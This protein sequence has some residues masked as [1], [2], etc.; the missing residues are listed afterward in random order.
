VESGAV[1]RHQCIK[2]SHSAIDGVKRQARR[3]HLNRRVGI[4]CENV[5]FEDLVN[6]LL[7]VEKAFRIRI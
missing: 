6:F 4:V 7:A 2:H 1:S 5:V 3:S